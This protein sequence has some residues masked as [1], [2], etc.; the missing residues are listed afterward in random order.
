[1]AKPPPAETAG[2]DTG[3]GNPSVRPASAVATEE[4]SPAR[5]AD[6][7]P[8]AARPTAKPAGAGATEGKPQ[9]WPV[10]PGRPTWA[11]RLRSPP[12]APRASRWAVQRQPCAD[13]R[14]QQADAAP[15]AA[16]QQSQFITFPGPPPSAQGGAG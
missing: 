5:P 14:R 4:R 11:P 16:P 8:A 13:Y 10:P 12:P 6:A 9:A 2:A 1:M 7:A 15:R 3:A